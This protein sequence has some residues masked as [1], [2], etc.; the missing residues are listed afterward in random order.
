MFFGSRST[1]TC[2]SRAITAS[3]ACFAAVRTSGTGSVASSSVKNAI[4]VSR[5][6]LP[7]LPSPAT[8]LMRMR[9][10]SCLAARIKNATP[11]LP[12]VAHAAI[13]DFIATS[14]DTS[15]DSTSSS[16]TVPTRSASNA[17]TLSVTSGCVP[18]IAA[19]IDG[20]SGRTFAP[21]LVSASAAACAAAASLSRKSGASCGATLPIAASPSAAFARTYA[22]PSIKSATSASGVSWLAPRFS[23]SNESFLSS[24]SSTAGAAAAGGPSTLFT[25]GFGSA[26]G[27]DFACAC[28]FAFWPSPSWLMGT[29]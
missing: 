28:D 13:T 5:S 29:S 24:R 27:S 4:A 19:T 21:S 18:A 1:T 8:A 9:L 26:F 14:S 22:R 25:A 2:F 23:S 10:R 7:S 3:A 6:A 20:T 12:S 15:S 17:T 11:R 16:S